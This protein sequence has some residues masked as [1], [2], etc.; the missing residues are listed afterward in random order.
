MTAL[1]PRGGRASAGADLAAGDRQPCRRHRRGIRRGVVLIAAALLIAQTV[2]ASDLSD[3]L[4]D[5][6]AAVM[7]RLSPETM[8][9]L[10]SAPT[11][12]YSLDVD[13]EY[14]QDSNLYYLTAITQDSS[15]LVLMPGN[16][17]RREILFIKDRD[18]AQEHWHGRLL[19]IEQA[20]ERTGIQTVLPTSEFEPFIAAMLSGRGSGG[21]TAPEAARFF[22]ALSTGRAHVALALDAGR[23]LAGPPSP[24]LQFVQRIRE[25]FVGFDTID[26]M[27]IFEDL[28]TIKTPY[29][30]KVLIKSLEISSLA[31]TAGMRAARPGAYEYE[32]KAAIEA[33]HR[34]RG[35]VSWSYPSIVGSGP[36][37]TILH[38]PDS[39]R[40]MQAGDLLLVDAACN[41][42][43][44][45]GDITRTY[46]VSGTF[47]PLQKDLYRIVLQAQEEGIA[48]ARPGASLQDIHARTVE[49]IK[50][51][52]LKLG[53]ITDAR[54]DQYRL[55]Y[56][57]GATHFIGIDVHDVG[58]RTGPLKPG[59]AFTI[60]PGI[61]I[62]T[63]ALETLPR[64][65]DNLTFIEQVGSAVRRY[66]DIGIR[67]ED[68][69]LLEDGGLR[70]LS[71]AVPKTI[72]AIEAFLRPQTAAS[73][74]GR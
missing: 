54:G 32:V 9:I 53:L 51:G 3:D 26:A 43:Y 16:V 40:Q 2:R 17:S 65:P 30:R 64:T 38:Y 7:A 18:P 59:S 72:D 25:R 68:S 13:Y 52:L 62:R 4:R 47:S 37:A 23:S 36:N 66:A 28:R 8:T 22:A 10:W 55:W 58:N 5:R 15:V 63:G 14:R 73:N 69:F 48:A 71:A 74:G 49:V 1:H 6:R 35:A 11:Q 33:V 57:H 50:A 42:A 27:P 67:I 56:T 46:P 70:N 31:Q 24:P 20:R 41:Y 44:M 21:I 12:R 19:S 61:Y 29:E 45:S 39:D 60:E 34:G